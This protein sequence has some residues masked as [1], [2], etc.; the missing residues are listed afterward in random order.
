MGRNFTSF[1][2]GSLQFVAAVVLAAAVITVSNTAAARRSAVRCQSEA[3]AEA[4]SSLVECAVLEAEA[5]END[6]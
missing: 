4:D 5:V 6:I 2:R 1:R 3:V